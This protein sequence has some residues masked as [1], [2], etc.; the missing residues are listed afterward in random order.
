M[1][2]KS[3]MTA[4]EDRGVLKKVSHPVSRDL[5]ITEIYQRVFRENGPALLFENV[6]DTG[7]P[8]LINIFGTW[9]RVWDV[10]GVASEK[11]LIGRVESLLSVEQP[12]GLLDKVRTLWKLKDLA[13]ILPRSAK[14]APCQQHVIEGP[15]I[16][17]D[18]FPVMKCWPEDAGRFITL[19]AVITKDAVTGRQNMGM[20]RMQVIDRNR[21]AMHWHPS[22]GG[23]IHLQR[24]REKGK[25]L[26]VAVA[27]GCEPAVT[28]CATAP[29]PPDVGE[30]LFAGLLMGRPV[31]TVK[32]KTVDLEVPAESQI[33]LEGYID[34]E[35]SFMEGPFGDHTGYYTPERIFPIFNVQAVT[36]NENPVYPSIAVGWPPLEDVLLGKLTE[37][38]FFP[39][40]KFVIPEIR[41]I[42]IPE[43]GVFHNF[44]F[45]SID[46]RYPG[47]AY[48]VMD[49]LWGLGQMSA[50]KVIAVF[51]CDVNVHDLREVLFHLGNNIDPLRDVVLKKGPVDILDH[52]SLEEG[53][54]GKMG[55]DATKKLK[56]EGLA[57]PWPKRAV[58]DE[59]TVKR[60]DGIWSLLGL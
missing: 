52:A 44:V 8:L 38:L 17:L 19:P 20:Y 11:E 50:T 3:L 49:S 54:G 29:L 56:E 41:D 30:L 47:Q 14:K 24:A 2:L 34:E 9:E 16:N 39:L 25:R 21:T 6:K 27:I 1:D 40:I 18:S 36:L 58:M 53:F 31:E 35:D 4:W 22:K 15:D 12:V 37:R 46:K 59:E 5:E 45:V 23:N 48:K 33:V 26:E 32:C 51:D 57:R 7:Y 42:E 60:I 28:Y 43:A 13:G 10:F 55:I